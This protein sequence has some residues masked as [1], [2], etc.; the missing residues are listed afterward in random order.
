MAKGT[1]GA[2]TAVLIWFGAATAAE[3]QVPGID[4]VSPTAID[5]DD[6]TTTAVGNVTNA[7]S[8]QFRVRYYVDGVCKLTSA[9]AGFSGTTVQH[10]PPL[11]ISNW[12]LYSGAQFKTEISIKVNYVVYTDSLTITVDPADGNYYGFVPTLRRVT[13]VDAE[14][15]RGLAWLDRKSFEVVA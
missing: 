10:T 1:I 7:S 9:W 15:E 13:P 12:G 2:W 11:G 14:A 8:R 5:A 6:I 4:V 3:A